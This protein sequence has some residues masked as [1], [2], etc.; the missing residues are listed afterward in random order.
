MTEEALQQGY[1]SLV[2]PEP[3]KLGE[4]GETT[5]TSVW[6][7]FVYVGITQADEAKHWDFGLLPSKR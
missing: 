2:V 1:T 6:R 5:P 7:S 4:A 3:R